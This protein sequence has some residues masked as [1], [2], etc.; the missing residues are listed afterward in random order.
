VFLCSQP[1][2]KLQLSITIE[3]SGN[4]RKTCIAFEIYI[5]LFA[6]MCIMSNCPGEVVL[7]LQLGTGNITCITDEDLLYRDS[8]CR[9]YSNTRIPV[10]C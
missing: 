9:I 10:M 3:L 8:E 1:T 4:G 6:R 7:M 5:R 2:Q